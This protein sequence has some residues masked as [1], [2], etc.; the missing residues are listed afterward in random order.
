MSQELVPVSNASGTSGLTPT[1]VTAP[2]QTRR[3]ALSNEF[4]EVRKLSLQPTQWVPSGRP[5]YRRLPAVGETYQVDFFSDGDI[6]FTFIPSGGDQFGPGSMYVSQS[7]NLDALLIYDGV[8]V[9]KEGTTPVPKTI[10]DFREI[11]LESGRFLVCYQLIFDD[12]PEP[13]PFQITD[14]SLAGQDFDS[15]DSASA[16]FLA[17][18]V[19]NSNAWPY[20]ASYAFT[21]SGSGLLWKNYLDLVNQVPQST[22]GV[23]PGLPEAY[24]PLQCWLEWSSPLPWKLDNIV[25][26]TPLLGSLPPASLYFKENDEW[27]LV[28]TNPVSTDSTG[29]FWQ[30]QTDNVPQSNWRVEWPD[31]TKMEV[32]DITVSGLIYLNSRPSTERAR[33]Q[34]AIYPTN[35]VPEDETLCRLAI[36][37]VNEFEL[38]KNARGEIL[39]EDIRN[40]ANRDY[41]PIADWLTEYWDEQLTRNQEKVAAYA[42]GFMAPPT[43]LKL[44]Y[45]DLEKYGV[46][47]S[48]EVPPYPPTPPQPTEV[49]LI[50]ATVS[51][52]PPFS[53]TPQLVSATVSFFT[54]PSPPN[55]TNVYV[56]VNP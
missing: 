17:N 25:L 13:L 47:I 48:N 44:S 5:I 42:P 40:I 16:I 8:V 31:Y 9:W 38:Q 7:D 55:I 29:N 3:T 28:Q 33:A 49:N 11:G 21:P 45:V 50:G 20:P 2:L 52:I 22:A 10:V 4:K 35:L 27:V 39:K 36:I 1:I 56:G 6:G 23:I 15:N 34:L 51:L 54:D 53:S 26:R 19:P 14:F 12:A 41:E 30:F 46:A 37:N 43:L 32:H 24:Q 18:S